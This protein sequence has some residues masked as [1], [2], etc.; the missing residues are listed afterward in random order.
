MQQTL[1]GLAGVSV[2]PDALPGVD[3][4]WL[5]WHGTG[6]LDDDERALLAQLRYDPAAL[7]VCLTQGREWS[8]RLLA[9]REAV[10]LVTVDALRGALARV[11]PVSM[12]EWGGD[13]GAYAA[14]PERMVPDD[15]CDRVWLAGALSWSW[16][17]WWL[18]E[19]D[20]KQAVGVVL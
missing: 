9:S 15:V 8:R 4:V 1:T 20:G 10:A 3:A 19:Q 7:A 12:P 18:G 17:L 5:A 16:R 14:R 2:D 13:G 11:E 6:W